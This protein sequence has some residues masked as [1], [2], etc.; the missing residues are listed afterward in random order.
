MKNTEKNNK[1]N[2]SEKNNNGIEMPGSVEIKRKRGRPKKS[3]LNNKNNILFNKKIKNKLE[4]N[5]GLVPI[6]NTAIVLPHRNDFPRREP[7]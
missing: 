2:N 3:E 1:K 7:V 6:E 5:T 4:N